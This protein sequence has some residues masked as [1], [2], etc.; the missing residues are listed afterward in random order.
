MQPCKQLGLQIASAW[1]GKDWPL[2]LSY[3]SR[4]SHQLALGPVK[5]HR[6]QCPVLLWQPGRQRPLGYFL[7]CG[8]LGSGGVQPSGTEPCLMYQPKPPLSFAEHSLPL[9]LKVGPVLPPSLLAVLAVPARLLLRLP[10]NAVQHRQSVGQPPQGQPESFG[11]GS[12]AL[13]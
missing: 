1:L 4:V 5:Q 7:E 11:A 2:N 10:V 12:P 9:S 6:P 8:S 3:S 13:S